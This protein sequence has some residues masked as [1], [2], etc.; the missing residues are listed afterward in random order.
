MKITQIEFIDEIRNVYNDNIDVVVEN[1]EGFRY[2]ITV[3][4]IQDLLEEMNQE[5]TNFVRPGSPRIIVKKLTEEI[6]T[7]AI[8]AYAEDTGYWLK[9]Y[10]FADS[11]DMSIFDKL[12]AE[13]LEI[14][15]EWAEDED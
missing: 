15:K 3:A 14:W 2:V 10:Q 1:E 5:K 13:D 12:E 11:I 6:I 8:K 9:L 7:E 4:T